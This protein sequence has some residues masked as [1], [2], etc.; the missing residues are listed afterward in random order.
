MNFFKIVTTIALCFALFSEKASASSCNFSASIFSNT[1]TIA[2]EDVP[3]ISNG[4][5][6]CKYTRKLANFTYEYDCGS[7]I[8]FVWFDEH[9]GSLYSGGSTEQ[10]VPCY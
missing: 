8:F 7:S 9:D 5:H 1:A 10:L 2:V 3:G 4:K 6:S